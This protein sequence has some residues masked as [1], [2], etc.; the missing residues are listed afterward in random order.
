[1]KI[2]L[3][4]S[5]LFLKYWT[6][7][8]IA[9]FCLFA[10]AGLALVIPRLTGHAVDLALGSG[11]REALIY[12][13]LAIAVVGLLRSILSYSQNY[14]AEYLSHRV[15][16][17]LRNQIYDR[18]QRLSYAFY[19]RSQTGQLMSRA[20]ADVEGIRMFVGFALLRGVYFIVLLIV[21]SVVL[22][23][24]DWKL[25]ILSLSVL[26]FISYR[27][28]TISRKL[29]GLWMKIRQNVGV[30]GSIVQENLTGVR[31]VRAFA[32]EDMES[33][34]FRRQ[35][36]IIYKQEI[37]SNNLL[38][39]NSPV[40]SFALLFAMGIILWY[41]GR[42][43]VAGVLTQGELAQFLLYLVML[44]MPVRM[45]GWLTI[46][47]SRAMSSGQRI[48]EII[49]EVSPVRDRQGAFSP[50]EV[51]GNVR[52]ENVSFNYESHAGVLKD[53][54]F[55]A[56]SGQVVALVGASGS[57]KTTIASLIPR[58]YDVSAGRITIDGIDIR[59]FTLE[60]LR[61]QV[62]IIHQDV[63]L[64]SAT[65][66]E[67]I[68]YGRPGASNEEVQAAARVAHLHDFIKGLPEGYDTWIGERGITLSGGQ[69]QRMAIARSMLL[70]PRII[71][72]DD[73]TSSMDTET[74]YYVQEAMA[75][76]VKG[77]TVFI[78]AQRLRSF[79]MADLI[80]VLKDGRIEE[81]GTHQELVTR[82][83]IYA[84]LYGAQFQFQEGWR[85][86]PL[87][88]DFQKAAAISGPEIG[89]NASEPVRRVAGNGYTGSDEVF[90]GKPFDLRI[91]GRMFKYFTPY[92]I[93]V[94][95]TIAATLLY[96]FTIVINP[97]LVGTAIDKYIVS[98][99]LKGLN[100][101]VLFF[102]GNALLNLVA[103]YVQIRAEVSVGQGVL[104]NLRVEVF[105]HLQRLSI[106][107]FDRNAVGRIMSRVQNDVEQLG[108]FLDSGA[109]WVAGE[110]VSLIAI[111][112]MMFAM[113]FN[114]ALVTLSVIPVLF[115]FVMLWQKNARISFIRVRSAIATV[116][117][118]LQEN[119]SGVRVIQSLSR[120][121]INSRRFE[122]VNRAHFKA[123]L[124]AGR[125][126]ATMTPVVELLAALATSLIIYFGGL[127][128]LSGALLVGTLVAFAL[129]IQRFFDPI[130]TLAMHYTQLQRAVASGMRIFELLDTEP[131]IVTGPGS[132]VLPR[133]KGEVNFEGVSF[134]YE[135]EQE[136]LRDI[137]LR[138]PAGDTVALVGPTGAGKST[139]VSLLARFY[140]VTG[141]RLLVD[142]HD[143]R[144]LDLT[145][146]RRQLGMVL[147]DPFLFSGTVR[148]NICY[149]NP[150]AT[151]EEIV[152][153]AKSIGAYEFIMKM[154]NGFDSV[155]Q[156]RGQNV[157]MGQRQ[158]LS[159]I[160]ALLANPAILLLDEAT[161]N[162]DSYSENILQQALKRLLKDRTSIIIAHRLST[163]RNADCIVVLDKGRIV[164]KGRHDKI[165]ALGGLYARL[166][167][168]T[169]LPVSGRSN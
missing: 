24:L 81:R 4:I 167:E 108:E 69:K 125:L 150:G 40:M 41:G 127:D 70:N 129:Y 68:S 19:D 156:E 25:A 14:L 56:I 29:R 78:I 114:L 140:D 44:N 52:F 36:E 21:I 145:S 131:E 158:L 126:S 117:T 162:V 39:T 122:E 128:V 60:S 2:F 103:Y 38:A 146:Y 34:K 17:D 23:I 16:Y 109:F 80:L 132:I 31:V 169:Y 160:R 3:R 28:I 141:G 110:I 63:F 58:F 6:R 61:S 155:L 153:A 111:I 37:E 7:A 100:M 54:N 48:F 163:V 47:F 42:Q 104:L 139:M 79:N 142:G 134:S 106:R 89:E 53:I 137:N 26:P 143:V 49:D 92:R 151:D 87:A 12:T 96:T 98:G 154:E 102:L 82:N 33:M 86:V 15:A 55:E 115:T 138:I 136:V 57:G 73:S 105:N 18:L 27:T 119:I 72:M 166:Y 76:L 13:A 133:L 11:Q 123:N 112:S 43:V 97:Y 50:D 121:D 62:G 101:M 130:R 71:I 147:Q 35:A 116:N 152:A 64:F 113:N 99:N 84:R 77:R 74:E 67:N 20:T 85:E 157:S 144:N 95:L 10:G 164:E 91:V 168:M 124:R 94:P 5:T 88:L 46:L 83:G 120:E 118:A 90:F 59:D 75:E 148:E 165:L 32:R 107:F 149:G 161:A 51:R 135:A 9:Y 30:L 22:F 159:F 66:R 1:M 8:V 93:A 65:I 45:I